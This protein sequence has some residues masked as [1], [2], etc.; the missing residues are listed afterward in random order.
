MSE[1]RDNFIKSLD[2]SQCGITFKME[3]VFSKLK[4]K[5]TELYMKLVRNKTQF[6]DS[7]RV[8]QCCVVP[9]ISVRLS[10]PQQE[11]N[12]KPQYFTFRWL[13]LLLSQEFLLPDVIRIWDSL[14]SEQDRFEFLIPVC[15]AMLMYVT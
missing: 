4:E 8:F 9:S 2:D 12:I 10:L 1:N 7:H 15:C 6:C 14:F 5:D 13:T 11:Q 3:S